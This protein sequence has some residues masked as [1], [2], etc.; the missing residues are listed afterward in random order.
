MHSIKALKCL[1]LNEQMSVVIIMDLCPDFFSPEKITGRASFLSTNPKVGTHNK[2][3]GQ[4][5]GCF[6]MSIENLM[7]A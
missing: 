4:M 1:M 7:L 5:S 2:T 6:I 3:P